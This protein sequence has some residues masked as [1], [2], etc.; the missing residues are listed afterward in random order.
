VPVAGNDAIF[1]SHHANI[2]R[3]WACW[4]SLHGTPA[5]SWQNQTFSF[6]DETGTLQTQP[7]GKFI[8]STTLGYVY[9]NVSHC[10]RTQLV[11][12]PAPTPMATAPKKPG[13]IPEEMAMATI[14]S[15]PGLAIDRPE[16]SF[17]ID[18]PR[19]KLEAALADLQRPGRVEL[20]LRDVTAASHPGVL[21]NVYLAKKGQPSV[22]AQVGTITWFGAFRHRHD[23]G[24]EKRTLRY[25]VTDELRELGGREVA[26]TGVTVVIEATHGRKLADRAAEE[27]DHKAASAQFRAEAN[28]R[29]GAIELHAVQE[30]QR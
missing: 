13:P 18:V 6:V 21:F 4:Q 9:D 25:D 12:F 15:L 19:P 14:G 10:S 24:G 23:K 27:A 17:D 20:V 22:R 29:I 28:L 3:L 2:D 26:G 8:D 5:G 30:P 7:V 11:A 16:K 1:Y